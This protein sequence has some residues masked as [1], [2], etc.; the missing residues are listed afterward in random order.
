[1]FDEPTAEFPFEEVGFLQFGALCGEADFGEAQESH[2]EG[3]T[4]VFLGLGAGVGA[5]LVGGSER[6][7]RMEVSRRGHRLAGR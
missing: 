3:R 2:A 4:G 5:E 6:G 7:G 1:M